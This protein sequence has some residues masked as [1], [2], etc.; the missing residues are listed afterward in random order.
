MLSAKCAM[1]LLNA[2]LQYICQACGGAATLTKQT[3]R[4]SEENFCVVNKLQTLQAD[5]TWKQI[6]EGPDGSPTLLLWLL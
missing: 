5:Y 3:Q 6:C 1:T 4:R 2:Q